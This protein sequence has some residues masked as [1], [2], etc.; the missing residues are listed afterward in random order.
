MPNWS[1]IVEE[2]NLLLDQKVPSAIDLIRRKYIA[3]VSRITQ[4]ETIIYASRWIQGDIPPEEQ[5]LLMITDDDIQAFMEVIHGMSG[6]RLNLILHSPGGVPESAEAIV[7][8]I[9]QKFKHVDVFVPT[10][11]MSAAT[12]IACS[13]DRIVLG[14]HSFLG[15]IDPQLRVNTPLGVTFAPAQAVLDQFKKAKRECSNPKNLAAWI[16]M[17]GQY[18]PHLLVTCENVLKLSEEMVGSWLEKYMF[19]GKQKAKAKKIAKQLRDHQHF[20]S[21]NRH[22][23]R[24][25]AERM[26]LK[27]HPLEADQFLQDAVLSVFHATVLTF[28]TTPAA[29]ITEN[30]LGRAFIRMSPTIIQKYQQAA[31]Q[32]ISP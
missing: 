24:I 8:Y 17:L 22:I 1:G 12:M 19:G 25:E 23:S 30:N 18:G 28:N 11:A 27:I 7:S 10:L 6:E 21:H 31:Q 29:K 13:A 26:G 20:K 5:G 15:P 14:K 32:I 9:R 3:E 2:Y 4:C 16:P